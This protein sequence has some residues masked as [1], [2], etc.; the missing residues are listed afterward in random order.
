MKNWY[1]D[2]NQFYIMHNCLSR[3]ATGSMSSV[4][5][6][7]RSIWNSIFF[8]GT[9]L[10]T[11]GKMRVAVSSWNKTSLWRNMFRYKIYR[12]YLCEFLYNPHYTKATSS[13]NKKLRLKSR[14][15]SP[16]NE[17]FSSKHIWSVDRFCNWPMAKFDNPDATNLAMPWYQKCYRS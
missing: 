6:G 10:L 1:S 12:T 16:I 2:C 9:S 14:L 7:S 11:H 15:F 13:W 3:L 5:S 4:Q 17:Q 8:P